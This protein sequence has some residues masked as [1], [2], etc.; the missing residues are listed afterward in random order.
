MLNLN[1]LGFCF[2][3][4]SNIIYG[5]NQLKY[6]FVC[7]IM[8]INVFKLENGYRLEDWM[9]RLSLIVVS[10]FNL[11]RLIP[12]CIKVYHSNILLLYSLVVTSV[13]L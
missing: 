8:L 2:V 9:V 7:F 3:S 11:G 5:R 12:K 1:S 10:P 6:V 13:L 4:K